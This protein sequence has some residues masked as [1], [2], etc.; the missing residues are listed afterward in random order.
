M[1]IGII[2]G[3]DGFASV[4][5]AELAKRFLPEEIEVVVVGAHEPHDFEVIT[6]EEI[7]HFDMLFRERE[8]VEA[9]AVHIP[10]PEIIAWPQEIKPHRPRHNRTP[11]WR[12]NQSG[13]KYF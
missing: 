2:G 10:I 13:S 5:A 4:L 8:S 7:R 9:K 6:A 11:K 12:R 1:K 3:G